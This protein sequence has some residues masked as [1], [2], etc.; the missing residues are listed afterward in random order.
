MELRLLKLVFVDNCIKAIL[1]FVDEDGK[2]HYYKEKSFNNIVFNRKI[3][4]KKDRDLQFLDKFKNLDDYLVFKYRKNILGF[5]LLNNSL[6]IYNLNSLRSNDKDISTNYFY[7]NRSFIESFR[8]SVNLNC[9]D[10]VLE[11]RSFKFNDLEFS[12]I[13]DNIS[14]SRITKH[15]RF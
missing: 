4:F 6:D 15:I 3:K 8:S 9:F 5:K 13:N 12:L 2:F 7:R 10:K 1:K 14:H 11:V